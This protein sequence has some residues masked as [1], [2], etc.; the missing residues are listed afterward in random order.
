MFGKN[1]ELLIAFLV[2]L[3]IGIIIGYTYT[4]MYV[5]IINEIDKIVIIHKK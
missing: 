3:I 5:V 2:P 4:R 1:L